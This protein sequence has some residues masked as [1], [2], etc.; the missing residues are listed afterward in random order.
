MRS[1]HT[2]LTKSLR[3]QGVA[4]GAIT[5]SEKTPNS[6]PD[7]NQT[8]LVADVCTQK[9]REYGKGKKKII[10]V[11]CGMKENII[12]SLLEFPIKIKRVPF[13]YDY[14][15]EEFDGVFISN[16]PGDPIVCKETVAVCKRR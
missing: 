4:L 12:R 3:T 14:S 8:H 6:F 1:R 15:E 9:V 10:A 7:P 13:D 11:D 2:G 16:G 5:Q